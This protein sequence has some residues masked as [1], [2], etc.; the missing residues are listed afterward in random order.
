[1]R[2]S[3]CDLSRTRCLFLRSA[4]QAIDLIDE[5]GSRVRLQ[6]AQ[7]G[8]ELDHKLRFVQ[9]AKDVAVLAQVMG[10]RYSW[11]CGRSATSC[12]QSQ[13]RASC[14]YE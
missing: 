2:L 3:T 12:I 8:R 4:A 10:G 9:Q 7:E 11:I 13:A 14:E 1:M 5:A 6:H